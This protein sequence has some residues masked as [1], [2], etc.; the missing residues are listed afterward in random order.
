[1]KYATKFRLVPADH[2]STSLSQ[3]SFLPTVTSALEGLAPKVAPPSPRDVMNREYKHFLQNLG[4]ANN[5]EQLVED[6]AQMSYRLRKMQEDIKKREIDSENLKTRD[7]ETLLREIIS[8]SVS[9]PS[10]PPKSVNKPS[11]PTKRVYKVSTR[12]LKTPSKS[13]IQMTPKSKTQK[14]KAKS[15]PRTNRANQYFGESEPEMDWGEEVR[16]VNERKSTPY[17]ET[18]ISS[19]VAFFGDHTPTT[20]WEPASAEQ[21]TVKPSK[22]SKTVRR[23]PTKQFYT[24]PSPARTRSKSR[25]DDDSLQFWSPS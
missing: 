11:T 8:K 7:L 17:P 24:P 21:L 9:N 5:P 4:N 20:I 18:Q 12:S 10:T 1:M 15:E 3:Q 19:D 22:L 25:D 6:D 23:R 2:Q 14:I 16:A 13:I